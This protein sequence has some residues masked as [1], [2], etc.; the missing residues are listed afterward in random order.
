MNI[1]IHVPPSHRLSDCEPIRRAL[2]ESGYTVTLNAQGHL[3]ATHQSA[4]APV[5]SNVT[6]LRPRGTRSGDRHA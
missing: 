6:P 5:P 4:I 2:L 1:I 3:E